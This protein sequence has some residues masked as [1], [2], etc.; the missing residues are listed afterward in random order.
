MFGGLLRLIL[1]RVLGARVMLALA[2]FGWLRRMLSGRREASRRTDL[3]SAPGS[4][5]N[6]PTA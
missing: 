5:R 3:P 2:A 4:S 1:F 6:R